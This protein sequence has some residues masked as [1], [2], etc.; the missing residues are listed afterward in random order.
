MKIVCLLTNVDIELKMSSI[1]EGIQHQ[2]LKLI[3]QQICFDI[4]L[5][6]KIFEI[7]FQKACDV[8]EL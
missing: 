5:K 1:L 4:S 8:I 6:R 2:N 7:S 3:T